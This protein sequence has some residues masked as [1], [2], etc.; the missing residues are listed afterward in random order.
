VTVAAPTCSQAGSFST[1]AM[2]QGD[3]AES[4]LRAEGLR[5]WILR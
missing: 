5:Y 3:G 4:F 1:L 2:L